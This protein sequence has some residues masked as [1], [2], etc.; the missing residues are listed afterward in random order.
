MQTKCKVSHKRCSRCKKNKPVTE[1]SHDRSSKDNY[2]FYCKDCVREKRGHKKRKPPLWLWEGKRVHMSGSYWAVTKKRI[3]RI[4]A[5]R[6]LGRKLKKY[7]CVHHLNGDK[8]DNRPENLEVL[9][10][11]I[12][13]IAI[14][15]LL[16]EMKKLE[17]E[18]T[19]LKKL[20][21]ISVKR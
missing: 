9:P 21:E 18:N 8:L 4:I 5:E 10:R 6:K 11:S 14:D 3:H 16:K 2:N 7:E 15:R 13:N 20:L 1:F 12:D 19:K 17:E